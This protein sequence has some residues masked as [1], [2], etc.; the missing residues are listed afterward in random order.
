M[1]RYRITRAGRGSTEQLVEAGGYGY[2][3]SCVTSEN[4]PARAAAPGSAEIV[5]LGFDRAVTASEALAEATRRGLARPTYEDAFH[6]G[7]EHPEAQRAHPIVFLHEP[8]VGYFGRR[9]VL[10]LWSNAGRRELGLEG[11]DDPFAPDCRFAFVAPAA[12]VTPRPFYGEFA[13]AYDYLIA[14]PVAEECAGM[15][16]ALARRGIGPGASLLDAGCG[17]GRYAV[18]LA[19]RGFVVTGVD[20]SPELLAEARRRP[21]DAG[22]RVRFDCGDLLALPGAAGFDAIVCRGVLNDLVETAERAAVF[23][24][25]ARALRPGG[26]LLLDVRDWDASVSGKTAQPVSE[27]RVTTPHGSLVFRSVTRLDPATRRLLVAECHTLTTPSGEVTARHDFVM[28]CWSRDELEG[29]LRAA[30]FEGMEYAGTYGSAPLGV[31]DRIVVAASP[32]AG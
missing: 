12:A 6:F 4:F 30:G 2:A 29:L 28:R 13:W 24:V 17:T 9:D 19:R 25:F 27:R 16:A 26:A 21:V 31:G 23:G 32:S 11:F 20:R 10:S 5:L 18:E 14:R 8:W 15:A 1:T 22:A 7:A 3:H